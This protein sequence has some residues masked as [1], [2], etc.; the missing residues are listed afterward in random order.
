MALCWAHTA[1]IHWM[2]PYLLASLLFCGLIVPLLMWYFYRI[3]FQTVEAAPTLIWRVYVLRY[4]GIELAMLPTLLAASIE[5][6]TVVGTAYALFG[7]LVITA[8]ILGMLLIVA[9]IW[10]EWRAKQQGHWHVRR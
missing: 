3:A 5:P 6:T 2:W 8:I 1:S 7:R 10:M 4:T 9:S